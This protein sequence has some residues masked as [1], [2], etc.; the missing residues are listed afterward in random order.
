MAK[1]TSPCY[2]E[3]AHGR[4]GAVVYRDYRGTAIAS[5]QPNVHSRHTPLV[6]RT[7]S[8]SRRIGSRWNSMTRADRAAWNR[9]ARMYGPLYQFGAKPWW[10]GFNWWMSLAITADFI[11]I[12]HSGKPP[13]EPLASHMVALEPIQV[14]KAIY[15]DYSHYLGPTIWTHWIEIRMMG[16]HSPGRTPRL[17]DCKRV[18]SWLLGFSP[19]IFVDEQPGVYTLFA[20]TVDSQ[21]LTSQHIHRSITMEF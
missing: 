3:E 16:P 19:Y 1:L 18:G 20:R 7:I 10:S 9:M 6:H 21:G 2:S 17:K 13:H 12:H 14:G 15:V 11:G 8:R 4:V 5:A